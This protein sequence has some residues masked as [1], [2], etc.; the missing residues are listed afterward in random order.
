MQV[1]RLANPLFNEVIVPMAAKDRWNATDP[2]DDKDFAQYVTR[3]ELGGLLP[4]L[5]PGVFPNLAGYQQ[6]RADLAAILLTGIP[7][8]VVP[9]FQN[10]TGPV[11]ADLL[12]LNLAVPPTPAPKVLGLIAGDPAGFP[13]GRRLAD[14]VVTIELRAIAGA[15]IPL[16]DTSFT[17]DDAAAAVTDGTDNTN[18]GFTD[19]FP[20][21][22]RRPVG[23][24]AGPAYR[25][26][27]MHAH[28]ENNAHAGRG[29]SVLL[30]IGGDVGAAVVAV[31]PALLGAE[32]EARPVGAGHPPVHA[33]VVARPL[34]AGGRLPSVVLGALPAGR[35]EL[36]VRPDGPV[37]LRLTVTGGAVAEA[38]W[39]S[40]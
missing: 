11:Q 3:P 40:G 33:G 36:Y 26:H 29:A 10:F 5:Y 30:D 21:V 17:P 22:G 23:S 2:C 39:P 8:G 37:R 13:N 24:R 4:V 18:A 9:G 1:S 28:P 35:Y 38:D 25:R 15:T 14:D 19:H 27:E 32:V 34:P 16:V 12:R 6:P 31:P 7:A 20:Y